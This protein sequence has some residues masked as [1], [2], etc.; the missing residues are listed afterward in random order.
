MIH[1]FFR[2][3]LWGLS[4]VFWVGAGFSAVVTV[5]SFADGRPWIDAAN[6]MWAQMGVIFCIQ[7]VLYVGDWITERVREINTKLDALKQQLKE[8]SE[9]VTKK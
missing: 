5:T 1:W 4:A 2:S 9:Q 8:L 7:F 3:V 6:R